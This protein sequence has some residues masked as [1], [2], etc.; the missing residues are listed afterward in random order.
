MND[1]HIWWYV[2]RSSAI[3][4]WILM[5]L[6]VVWGVL[7][8]TRIFRKVDNPGHLQ[9]LHRY[10]GGL[11]LLMVVVHV[12]SLM[13][14][15]WLHFTPLQALV[16]FQASYR[17]IP[18]ALGIGALYLLVVVYGSS[19]LRD[20]LPPRFW[21]GLHYVNYGA[22]LLIGFHAG[23]AGTDAGSWWYFAVSVMILSL[24]AI[25]IIVRLVMSQSPSGATGATGA[26]GS[27]AMVAG[28]AS[29]PRPRAVGPTAG[30]AE[31]TALL[32]QL[33]FAPTA[34]L[35]RSPFDVGQRQPMIEPPG[36]ASGISTMIVAAS[37]ELAVGVRGLRLVPAGGA[38]LPP[39]HPGAHLTL[40][41]PSGETR[42]Y[43]LCSDPADRYHYDIAV[44]REPDSRGGSRWI[45]ESLHPG[46]AVRVW[47]PRNHF[48]L[49]AAPEYLFVAGGIGITPLR[50]MI[51]SLPERREWKL[52]YLGRSR[53]TMAYLPELLERYPG[54]VYVYARDEHPDRLNVAEIVA[55][56]GGEVFCCGPESLIADV[57]SATPPS[58]FHAEHFEPVTR[59]VMIAQPLRISLARSGVELTVPENRSV[60]EVLEE[61]RVPL[62]ASCRRGVCG[63]CEVR[64]TGGVPEHRDSVL[65]DS[66]KDELGIMFPCVS[67]A[68]GDRLVLD[69]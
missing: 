6:A 29:A 14:D 41:L 42:Q 35:E 16:P 39:W 53:S 65:G 33:G 26:A 67:R 32:A 30:G 68:R 31:Q 63:T 48:P 55:G 57:E 59:P 51:E 62:L 5:T 13:L 3:L 36:T 56:L 19:L 25:A 58:R 21:K 1:P 64:V 61:N 23:L 17:T 34:V 8:S 47:Q 52:I 7:L 9:D 28:Q 66:E 44:L 22:V 43:S 50:S 46:M 45:H 12:V 24:T 15:G 20:R 2:T 38:E 49:I 69:I 40:E 60:L 10:F 4:A 37:F 27:G 18:V 54:R 11:S